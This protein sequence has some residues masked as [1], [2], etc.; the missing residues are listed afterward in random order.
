[1]NLYEKHIIPYAK[2]YKKTLLSTI[3]LGTLTILS[4]A[5]LTFTSGYLISRTSER[6][7][8]I[9]LVYIPIVAVRTFG[10][11]RAAL[12]YVERL[13]GHH[14]V[15]KMIADMRVHLYRVLEPQ[16]LF[17]RSRFQTGDL[18]GTLADDIE[19]LQDVYI[20]TLFPTVIGL[21]L[22][23]FSVIVLAVYDWKFALM[24]ALCLSIVSFVYPML[25]LYLM[26]KNQQ[27]SKKMHSQLYNTMTEGI[28]GLR[29]WI[30][31]GR[32]EQ[33]L[34]AF[35]EESQASHELDKK[36]AF[37]QQSRTVQ[38]QIFSGLLVVVVGIW[39]GQQAANGLLMPTYI[40]A[41]TL[42]TLPIV[43]GLIPISHAIER[44]P[45]YEASLKRIDLVHEYRVDKISPLE[46]QESVSDATITLHDVSYRYDEQSHDAVQRITLSIE[47]GQKIAILG[48][49]GA[50]KSTLIQL[51]LGVLQPTHG[52]VLIN[53][54]PAPHYGDTIYDV[55][56]VLNQKPYLF[57]TTVENNIKLGRLDAT[58]EDIQR[59]IN[60]VGLTTYLQ[61]LP[62]GSKTQMEETGQR[63]SGGERQRIALARILLKQNPVVILDEPTVGLDPLTEHSLVETIH[64]ALQEQTIIWVTHHL[65]GME[66]MDCIVFM[67]DGKVV[68][69]GTHKELLATNDRYR[70][71]YEIDRGI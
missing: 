44:L 12:R 10:I 55:V 61:S 67:E 50:G 58:P 40:A 26:K 13:L 57:A 20:R 39:A 27:H 23:S 65:M 52:S 56:S 29:D 69:Q 35:K 46:I 28:F 24:M 7:E 54:E 14:A 43:E 15:L 31:S 36:L 60:Q 16:A 8:N 64:D 59:V 42:V 47:Q 3:L 53:K 37:W 17:I 4:A 2:T 32:K 19:H 25:S 5:M 9:L 41:F 63:F 22:F 48:K 62:A 11:S 51:L 30:I 70:Q 18:L 21:F 6:P 49:S 1:M 38:L 34:S 68:M 45:A 71:L 66:K 33:F